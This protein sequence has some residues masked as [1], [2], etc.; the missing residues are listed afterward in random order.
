MLRLKDSSRGGT[1]LVLLA[2]LPLLLHL[3][4]YECTHQ[5]CKQITCKFVG[6]CGGA[7][8]SGS[9]CRSKLLHAGKQGLHQLL[10]LRSLILLSALTASCDL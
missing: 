10:Q 5:P 3:Q 4:L 2:H 1:C 7:S 8:S 6:S 9:G